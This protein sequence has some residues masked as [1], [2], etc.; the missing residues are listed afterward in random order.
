M[1]NGLGWS[2]VDMAACVLRNASGKRSRARHAIASRRALQS[3]HPFPKYLSARWVAVVLV[4]LLA[5]SWQ[6]FVTQTHVHAARDSYSIA[7]SG[8][9]APSKAKSPS[10]GAPAT[11]PICDEIAGGGSYLPPTPVSF[12]EPA[13]VSVWLD[14]AQSLAST[15]R[16]DSHAWRSRAPPP[17]PQA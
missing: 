11:C 12:H 8:N 3:R 17:P 15:V 10:S 14:V 1:F 5:F 6:S 13:A 2:A 16:Q 9:A 4:T 7:T